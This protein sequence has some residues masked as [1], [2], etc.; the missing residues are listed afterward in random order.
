MH[1]RGWG[2][3]LLLPSLVAM[4]GALC[5]FCFCSCHL[6]FV[7]CCKKC[8]YL[9]SNTPCLNDFC[10]SFPS[11]LPSHA[12]SICLWNSIQL[13]HLQLDYWELERTRKVICPQSQVSKCELAGES[14]PSCD[15]VVSPETPGKVPPA[16]FRCAVPLCH[17]LF[18]H[19][20]WT[21]L[22]SLLLW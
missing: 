21:P 8:S 7:H 15:F 14:Q 11:A 16:H 13:Q 17:G 12:W 20:L 1:V 3:S 10:L 19:A 22:Y 18:S 2:T 5:S 9:P 6:C 4:M